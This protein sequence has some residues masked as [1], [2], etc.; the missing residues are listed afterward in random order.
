MNAFGSGLLLLFLI[1]ISSTSPSEVAT[2]DVL[3]AKALIQKAHV[4]YLDVRTVEEFEKGHADVDKIINIPYML[5]TPKGKVK[6]PEFVNKVS[7]AFNKEDHLVVGCL[8]GVR[9][10]CASA[11]LLTHGFKNVKNMEGGYLDWVKKDF[12]VKAHIANEEL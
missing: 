10:L 6:N 11:D 5:Y 3:Q 2:I 7:V 12:P 9:S 8:S 1:F 4:Y